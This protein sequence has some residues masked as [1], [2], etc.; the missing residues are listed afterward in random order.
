[1]EN[2]VEAQL[3]LAEIT[4]RKTKRAEQ[5]PGFDQAPDFIIPDELNP[6]VVIEAKITSDDGTARDKI[7]RLIH[8][9]EISR[10]RV[11]R[12]QAGFQVVAC[13]DGRGFGIRREDMR[14]LLIK[15]EG[16]VFTLRTL[17]QLVDRTRL[18]NFVCADPRRASL[19]AEEVR[20]PPTTDHQR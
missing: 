9:A 8:L 2:A 1:M 15:V 11:A 12:G 17:D 14:R 16:K 3:Q 5:V 19:P 13:I 6:Q 10:E 18:S 20:E 4:Y 7:T